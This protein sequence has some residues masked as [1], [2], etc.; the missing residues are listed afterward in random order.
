MSRIRANLRDIKKFEINSINESAV[1]IQ[2]QVALEEIDIINS[3][4]DKATTT[5]ESALF[6]CNKA[7]TYITNIVVDLQAKHDAIQAEL[8]AL[9]S[10]EPTPAEEPQD[11]TECEYDDEGNIISSY[12]YTV[13]VE[14]DEHAQWASEVSRV[15]TELNLVAAKLNQAKALQFKIVSKIAELKKDIEKLNNIKK[16][17]NI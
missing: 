16:S 3:N 10:S 6:D 2:I 12:T 14:T 7:E 17:N 1:A 11:F 5:I 15:Q 13:M 8:D 9:I 4:I